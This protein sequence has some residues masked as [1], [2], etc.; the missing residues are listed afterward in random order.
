[1]IHEISDQ[2]LKMAIGSRIT[3]FLILFELSKTPRRNGA[4]TVKPPNLRPSKMQ[5][6]F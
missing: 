3:K 5:A 2:I 6:E 4:G 1:M